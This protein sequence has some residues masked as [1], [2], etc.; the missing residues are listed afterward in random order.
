MPVRF[1]IS[2]EISDFTTGVINILAIK[3]LQ[4]PRSRC[5]GGFGVVGPEDSGWLSKPLLT[6]HSRSPARLHPTTN[7]NNTFL[8]RNVAWSEIPH[9]RHRH[10]GF[11]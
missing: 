7:T 5:G 3:L 1:T 6:A 4:N 2:S 10:L 9:H 11:T 8:T